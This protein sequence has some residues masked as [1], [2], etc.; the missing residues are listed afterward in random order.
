MSQRWFA[1]IFL[2]SES[3]QRT[4]SGALVTALFLL[5]A[6]AATVYAQETVN[7]DEVEAA[8]PTAD[9]ISDEELADDADG[10]GDFLASDIVDDELGE[11]L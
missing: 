7:Y 2:K 1:N 10:G 5:A 11:M 6:T 9:W 4:G 8:D 3:Y